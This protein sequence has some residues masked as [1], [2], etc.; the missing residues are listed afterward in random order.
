MR[1]PVFELQGS[2]GTRNLIALTADGA[3]AV[4]TLRAELA[5]AKEQ[6]RR[7]NAVAEKAASELKAE[8][9]AHRRSEDKMANMALELQ[10]AACRYELL[11]RENKAKA[12]D[13]ENALQAVKETHSEIRAAREELRQPVRLRLGS[14]FYCELNSAI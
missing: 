2:A 1:T 7:S 9:V 3:A 8:Q 5:Q 4:E 10:N 14:P 6:A 11:K 13:L 12:A